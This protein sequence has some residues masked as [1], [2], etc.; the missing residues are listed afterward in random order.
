MTTHDDA[1]APPIDPAVLLLGSAPEA[2]PDSAWAGHYEDEGEDE[3]AARSW[4]A[5]DLRSVLDGTYKP[6]QPSVGERDDG[7]GVFYP[8]RINS[9]ASESEAGKTWFALI[10]CLQEI[11]KGNHV[12]YLDF[13]DDAGGVV[14][15]LLVLGAVP[16]DILDRFHYIRPESK[17]GPADL[18][19]LAQLMEL[20]PTLAVVDGVTEAMSLYGLELKDNTDVAAFGRQLLRPLSNAGAAV[21]TLDHVVK[22]GENRGRYSL[23]GVHKLNGLNGVMYM[24]ENLRPFGV[25]VTGKSRVRIAKD[26]PAQ[27]RK[28]GF[29]NK[30]GM[31]WYG[32]LVVA[33]HDASFAEA[34][35]Y[36]PVQTDDSPETAAEAGEQERR[37]RLAVELERKVLDVLRDAREPLSKNAVEGLVEGKASEVR[38]TLAALVARNLVIVVEGPR[39]ALLHSLAT[40]SHLVPPRPGTKSAPRPSSP[41][42]FKEGDGDEDEV[43]S[44]D[45]RAAGTRSKPLGHPSWFLYSAPLDTPAPCGN[46]ETHSRLYRLPFKGTRTGFC[47]GCLP[48]RFQ[49]AARLT[50]RPLC[51]ACGKATSSLDQLTHPECASQ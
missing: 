39:K 1:G 42:P 6:P 13:E 2:P 26:R 7:V 44:R 3:P 45:D 12:V 33:S 37:K 43:R 36:P 17:P 30:T 28:H 29:A 5:Q 46:C 34:H 41:S 25:G 38:R 8:G 51:A 23:G 32:D 14:G 48:A 19:D 4:Q 47:T 21:V 9:V 35:L 15:R 24:L 40:S 20:R 16:A 10:V 31:H 18:A 49:K 22:A 50:R 27:L 11:N